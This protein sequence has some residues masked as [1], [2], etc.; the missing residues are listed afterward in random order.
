MKLTSALARF[1][2]RLTRPSSTRVLRSVNAARSALGIPTLDCLPT[3]RLARYDNCPLARSLPGVVGSDGVAFALPEQALAVSAAWRTSIELSAGGVYIARLPRHLRHFV[4]D[5][6]L[7][8][9]PELR[10]R[11]PIPSLRTATDEEISR[12]RRRAA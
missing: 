4:E 12:S 7:G 5:F 3:G 10:D 8:A 11:A 2:V 9:Y 6:D 1:L